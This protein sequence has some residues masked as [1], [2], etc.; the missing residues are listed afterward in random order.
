MVF[1]MRQTAS[2]VESL[3][4]PTSNPIHTIH[5]LLHGSTFPSGVRALLSASSV[6]VCHWEFGGAE[7]R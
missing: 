3:Q 4:G 2:P 7:V 5:S 6:G 1:D